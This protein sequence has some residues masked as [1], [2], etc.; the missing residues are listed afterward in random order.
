MEEVVLCG[1]YPGEVSNLFLRVLETGINCIQ[2]Y[3]IRNIVDVAQEPIIDA[4][5]KMNFTVKHFYRTQ[6]WRQ[7]PILAFPDRMGA[8]LRVA[9][10]ATEINSR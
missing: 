5:Y 1:M 9:Y 6:R 10:H 4:P 2:L 8:N 7:T 3:R